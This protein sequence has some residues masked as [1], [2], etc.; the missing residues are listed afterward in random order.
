MTWLIKHFRKEPIIQKCPQNRQISTYLVHFSCRFSK[1]QLRALSYHVNKW[2][3]LHSQVKLR[4]VLAWNASY[5]PSLA[6][7]SCKIYTHQ[8]LQTFT[9]ALPTKEMKT[10]ISDFL[11]SSP[12]GPV[13]TNLR[14]LISYWHSRLAVVRSTKREATKPFEFSSL[15]NLSM[16]FKWGNLL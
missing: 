14:L 5:N 4:K 13:Q 12:F 7:I 15:Q 6:C 10:T 3:L 16:H 11:R 1:S 8:H 9:Y 2:D